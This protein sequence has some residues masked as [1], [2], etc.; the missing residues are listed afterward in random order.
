MRERAF[1]PEHG[2]NGFLVFHVGFVLAFWGFKRMDFWFF[3]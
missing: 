2:T 1:W 3:N